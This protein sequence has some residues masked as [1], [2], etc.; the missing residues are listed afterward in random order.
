MAAKSISSDQ[1]ISDSELNAL[2]GG[3]L[4]LEQS[5]AVVK[6]IET[7]VKERVDRALESLPDDLVS[8]FK[9]SGIIIAPK[10]TMSELSNVLLAH[11]KVLQESKVIF[12]QIRTILSSRGDED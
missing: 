7:F 10:D 9:E 8:R 12:G 2:S 1:K 6:L 4:T 3:A 11:R 5:R